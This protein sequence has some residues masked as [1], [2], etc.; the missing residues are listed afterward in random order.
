[1]DSGQTLW[2]VG[3]WIVENEEWITFREGIRL[4]GGGLHDLKIV[5][6]AARAAALITVPSTAR[7]KAASNL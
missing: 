3:L 5:A 1:M 7:T 6:G 4:V 2:G